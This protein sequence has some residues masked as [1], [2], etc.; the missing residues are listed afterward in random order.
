MGF[1][2]RQLTP[3]EPLVKDGFDRRTLLTPRQS[4]GD[5]YQ[6]QQCQLM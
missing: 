1:K 5:P 4:F 3:A 2:Q 6:P